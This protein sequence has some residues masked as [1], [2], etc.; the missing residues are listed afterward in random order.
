MWCKITS[1]LSQNN[2]RLTCCFTQER[3]SSLLG[4]GPAFVWSITST[5]TSSSCGLCPSLYFYILVLMILLFW[6]FF[7]WGRAWYGKIYFIKCEQKGVWVCRKTKETKNS[8]V[9]T[10]TA[11]CGENNA[12]NSRSQISLQVC[13]LCDLCD[14]VRRTSVNKT[15]FLSTPQL[16]V[17]KATGRTQ[18][19]K[20]HGV[21]TSPLDYSD[22]IITRVSSKRDEYLIC[23]IRVIRNISLLSH[24]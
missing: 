4:E 1:F 3:S 2:S 13:L 15:H 22:D 12:G 11:Y 19:Q 20:M 21:E 8:K 14:E 10:T 23:N 18:K 5:P 9:F 6:L 17:K 16:R 24:S 7:W